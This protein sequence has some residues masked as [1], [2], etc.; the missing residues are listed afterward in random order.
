MWRTRARG[1]KNTVQGRSACKAD[2]SSNVLQ[3]SNRSFRAF[4]RPFTVKKVLI[5]SLGGDLSVRNADA[6]MRIIAE[7]K[8]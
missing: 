3:G 6:C 8:F 2:L 1:V 7:M 4:S 5:G